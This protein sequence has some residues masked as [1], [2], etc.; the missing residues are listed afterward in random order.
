MIALP[1]A[2]GLDSSFFTMSLYAASSATP[3][4]LA[5]LSLTAMQIFFLFK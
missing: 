1:V 3:E 5:S 4:S 2:L